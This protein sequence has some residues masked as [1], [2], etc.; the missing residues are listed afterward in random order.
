MISCSRRSS[1]GGRGGARHSRRSCV[2][3]YCSSPTS[4]VRSLDQGGLKGFENSGTD[5]W[6]GGEGW[7]A[8]GIEVMVVTCPPASTCIY[9]FTLATRSPQFGGLRA[10]KELPR[11][12]FL[13]YPLFF[14]RPFFFY[15]D[16]PGK[17]KRLCVS[18]GC[19]FRVHCRVF[20]RKSF[21]LA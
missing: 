19:C 17:G 8:Y 16:H 15:L 9:R 20:S 21:R 11:C 1:C 2:S 18:H 6:G 4:W 14:S 3:S 12:F 5:L 13:S 7:G 10:Q